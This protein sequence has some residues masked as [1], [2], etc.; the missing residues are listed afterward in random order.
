MQQL[1]GEE[2]FTKQQAQ[3]INCV[4]YM[5][6]NTVNKHSS[7]KSSL[8]HTHGKQAVPSS[9]VYFLGGPLRGTSEVPSTPLFSRESNHLYSWYL[10]NDPRPNNLWGNWPTAKGENGKNIYSFSLGGP[11]SPLCCRS[12]R[13]LETLELECCRKLL[14]ARFTT[15]SSYFLMQ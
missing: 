13:G 12:T 9:K 7:T 1:A 14:H 8:A 4:T 15:F 6:N 10:H 3:C 11:F 2:P 5:T